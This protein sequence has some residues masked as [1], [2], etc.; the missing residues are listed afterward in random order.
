[1]NDAYEALVVD[2][3]VIGIDG[4]VFGYGDHIEVSCSELMNVEAFWETI[5]SNGLSI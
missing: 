4:E 3:D 2:C 1:M 5:G